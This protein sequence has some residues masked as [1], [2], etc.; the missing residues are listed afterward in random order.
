MLA[1]RWFQLN[2]LE[3]NGSCLTQLLCVDLTADTDSNTHKQI[4]D[5]PTD[6]MNERTEQANER[7]MSELFICICNASTSAH[8]GSCQR[9]KI[10]FDTINVLRLCMKYEARFCMYLSR[11]AHSH[12]SSRWMCEE[13]RMHI[14]IRYDEFSL[15]VD[16]S[17][18]HCHSNLGLSHR[19]ETSKKLKYPALLAVRN[20]VIYLVIIFITYSY[21]HHH[22]K[23]Q[24]ELQPIEY[25]ELRVRFELNQIGNT[26]MR[27]IIIFE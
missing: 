24:Y 19:N 10:S 11:A 4:T 25:T 7:Q 15:R 9:N 5:R 13:N 16:N 2:Y 27:I 12:R 18:V 3:W 22:Y 1:R 17:L 23:I 8:T 20:Y 26:L 14:P 21:Q 6:R